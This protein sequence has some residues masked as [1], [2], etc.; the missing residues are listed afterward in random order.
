[1]R[2]A[3]S[4][5]NMQSQRAYSQM[6]TKSKNQ[7]LSTK[8][9]SGTVSKLT[10]QI[11]N[12]DRSPMYT[13]SGILS[14]GTNALSEVGSNGS[15]ASPFTNSVLAS[16][17]E[18]LMS[19]GVFGG[20]S[21]G[22]SDT[23]MGYQMGGYTQ[24]LVTYSE[25]ESTSFSA[26]GIAVTEDGREISFDISV[27]MSRSFMQSMNVRVPALQSSLFD[28][29]MINI[30]TDTAHVSDQ[31][32]LFDIDSDGK[33]DRIS[34]PTEGTAFLA[35]DKNEDGSINDG[36]ELFGTAS[37]DGFKDLAM[38]DSDGNGW[39]DENDEIFD[40]LKVWYKTPSGED[41]LMSLKDA[42]VGAIYLGEQDTEFTINDSAGNTSAVVRSSG[43]FLKE[44]GG[45][46]TVQHVDLAVS[47][48]K[49][50]AP[51]ETD[52]TENV[53][54]LTLDLGSSGTNNVRSNSRANEQSKKKALENARLEK[55]AARKK[56]LEKHLEEKRQE[57]K[58]LQEKYFEHLREQRMWA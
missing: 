15:Q 39:I 5:V 13:K 27:S 4:Q 43:F 55:K 56:A 49:D 45:T 18:R 57:R 7:N 17:F 22:F 20:S 37:G 47:D 48:E 36:S 1:M 32:F 21:G 19:T 9:F 3:Q 52:D 25:S 11:R 40:K 8:S 16:L 30:G 10:S 31:K 34:M 24:S 50:T 58:E 2:I 33:A 23:G 6:G 41:V 29:L 35:L 38:Y 53:Q 44:S 14:D 28:P 54:A 26:D 12:Q 46:G 51:A 42:D